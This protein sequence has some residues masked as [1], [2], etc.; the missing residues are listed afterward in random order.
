MLIAKESSMLIGHTITVEHLISKK[1]G[2]SGLRTKII[3]RSSVTIDFEWLAL[4][5]EQSIL[6]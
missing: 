6:F 3:K 5:Y 4:I 1:L 2:P